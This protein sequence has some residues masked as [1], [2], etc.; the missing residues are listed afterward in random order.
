M[1]LEAFGNYTFFYREVQTIA[2]FAMNLYAF[3]ALFHAKNAEN[4]KERRVYFMRGLSALCGI[5]SVH[6]A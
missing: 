4:L 1:V 2:K 6:S 5:S 3:F